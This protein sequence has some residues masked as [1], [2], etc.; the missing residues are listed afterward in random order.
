MA[1]IPAVDVAQVSLRYTRDFQDLENTLY[2]LRDTSIDLAGLEALGLAVQTWWIT[3]HR[4]LVSAQVSYREIFV[5]DLTTQ[6]GLERQFIVDPP[7][8]GAVAGDAVPSNVT[9]SIS[10][11]TGFA[12]RSFRGRNYIPPINEG[13]IS[14]NRMLAPIVADWITVYQNLGAAIPADWTW[15]ILSR[16]SDGQPR[17]NGLPTPVLGVQ[18]ADDVVDSQ[19][20]RLPGR[21]T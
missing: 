12:G 6:S 3:E 1:F 7:Q 8:T 20:R 17:V 15:V 4:A 9:F 13:Q 10:F 18:V 16:F 11:R 19:R 21:G 5:R 14:A 2:F